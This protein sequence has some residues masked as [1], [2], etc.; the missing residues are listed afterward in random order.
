LNPLHLTFAVGFLSF[1]G[2]T[3][4]RV[5]L[6]LF[7]LHLGASAS[8]VGIL[9]AM[10]FIFPL[11]LSWPVGALSDRIGPRGPLLLST[12]FSGGGLLLPYFFHHI[13]ALYAAAALSGLSADTGRTLERARPSRA[14]FREFQFGWG[15]DQFRRSLIRRHGGRRLGARGG[16]LVHRRAGRAG[17]W[18]AGG[19]WARIAGGAGIDRAAFARARNAGR[20]GHPRW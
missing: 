3:A 6:S 14:Q 16:L 17:A 11:L 9:A 8:E 12:F 18:L 1:T 13:A 2:M 10:F 7:A 4:S 20:S 15:G 19:L 5:V